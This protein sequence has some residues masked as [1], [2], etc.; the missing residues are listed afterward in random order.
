VGDIFSVL[1][2]YMFVHATFPCVFLRTF[3]GDSLQIP[4]NNL[5]NEIKDGGFLG[6]SLLVTWKGG[7]SI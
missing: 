1:S 5:G 2:S 3:C 7:I 4:G 6:L